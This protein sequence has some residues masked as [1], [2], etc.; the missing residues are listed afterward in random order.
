[1]K[2]LV[3]AAFISVLAA[4]ILMA[5]GG[6]ESAEDDNKNTEQK[7]SDP[8]AVVNGEE[9]P[10]KEFETQLDGA[11]KQ[12]EQ[13]GMDVKGKEE[14]LQKSIIDQMVGL[15]LLKQEAKKEGYEVSEDE[16]DKRYEEFTSQF[17]SEEAQKKAFEESN[18]TEEKVKDELQQSLVINKYLKENTEEVKVSEDEMK[19]QYDTMSEQQGEDQKM[20]SYEESKDQI[21]QQ[22]TTQKEN[23][24]VKKL[25]EKLKK[26][27]EVDVKI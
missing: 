22:L 8:V 11:K 24:Q 25:I 12:Y 5:C 21:K 27:A 17:E 18:L 14:Q 10:R 16:V 9:I 23:E 3:L 1:M 4:F 19:K 13:M 20:P 15:E 6:N 26:D 2:K 7:E